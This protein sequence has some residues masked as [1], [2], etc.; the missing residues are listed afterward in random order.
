MVA[1]AQFTGASGDYLSTPDSATQDVTSD[2]EIWARIGPQDWTP[3]S[4]YTIVAKWGAPGQKSYLFQL[5]TNGKLQLSHSTNGTATFDDECPVVCGF[6]DGEIHWVRVQRGS[7][8][9]FS[10]FYKLT[11]ETVEIPGTGT[12][13]GLGSS[14]AS[15]AGNIFASTTEVEIG[16]F[17]VGTTNN[18]TGGIYRV[19]VWNLF[20][21][22]GG[23]VAADCR[24]SAALRSS[25]TTLI[26]AGTS[27]EV[28]TR[29]GAASF[30]PPDRS[31]L[32]TSLGSQATTS[33]TLGLS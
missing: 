22:L 18:F 25:D 14:V 27:A 7:G 32:V 4:V 17:N 8:N 29:H 15:A 24:V 31:I 5:N 1:Y 6:N 23:T 16:G 26:G 3:G 12:W 20:P 21:S 9:N 30:A 13:T 28:W 2:I 19:V 10:S 33:V 11:T